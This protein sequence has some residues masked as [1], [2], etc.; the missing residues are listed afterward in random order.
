M[1]IRLAGAFGPAGDVSDFGDPEPDHMAKHN[2]FALNPGEGVEPPLPCRSVR[3]LEV[4]S[5]GLR[6]LRDQRRAS[7][8][9]PEMVAPGVEGDG[10]NPRFESKLPY[11]LRRVPGESA[12]GADQSFLAQVLGLMPVTGH[13]TEA[14]VETRRHVLDQTRERSVEIAGKVAD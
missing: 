6:S 8:T 10:P 12:I 11:L 9:V 1:D 4:V 13:A 7:R 2:C 14:P 3:W 5:A